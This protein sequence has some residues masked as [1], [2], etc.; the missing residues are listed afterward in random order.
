MKTF[1]YLLLLVT[2]L[3][4]G[5]ESCSP[6]KPVSNSSQAAPSPD[7]LL[8]NQLIV[9]LKDADIDSFT[10]EYAQFEFTVQK[11]ISPRMKMWVLS[12]DDQKYDPNT[13][14]ETLKQS[15][16]V[17]NVEFDKKLNTRE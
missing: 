5:L 6:K 1:I 16:R 2:I 15:E 17:V 7:Y 13:V 4:V 14:L 11:R 10:K 12:F 3:V 8:T 9:Q